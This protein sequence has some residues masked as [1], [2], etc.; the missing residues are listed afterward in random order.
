MDNKERF[1]EFL[2][3]KKEGELIQGEDGIYRPEA[4]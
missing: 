3:Q 2:K 1:E 4:N